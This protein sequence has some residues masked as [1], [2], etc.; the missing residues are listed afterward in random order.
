MGDSENKVGSY[1]QAYYVSHREALSEK[2]AKLYSDNS[3]YRKRAKARAMERYRLQREGKVGRAARGYNI[4]KVVPIDGVDVRVHCVK[5]F[6]DKLGRRVQ[7]IRSWESKEI[8]PSPTFVDD[9]G[10]RW[11]GEEYMDA[12]EKAHKKFIEK[13]AVRLEDFK[14]MVEKEFGRK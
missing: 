7:T 13:N 9:R 1:N 5:E 6:A 12:V 10:R 11:Y 14:A 8:I 3:G 2:R 4:P